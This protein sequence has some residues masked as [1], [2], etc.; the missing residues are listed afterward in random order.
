MHEQ[1][2]RF[3]GAPQTQEQVLEG[4]KAITKKKGDYPRH[5]RV[6]VN[7]VG[8]RSC[9]YWDK[10][11]KRMK[12]LEDHADILLTARVVLR[13]VWTSGDTWGIVADATDLMLQDEIVVDC[14]F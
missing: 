9:R 10:D 13:S 1:S 3:F 4:Y 8:L 5:L 2:S 14:P 12:A 11:K 7:T 6:K